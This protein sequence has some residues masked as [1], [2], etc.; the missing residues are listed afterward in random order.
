MPS[1]D[2][3]L[4]TATPLQNSLLELFG[5]VS[6]IDEH[7]FGDLKSFREQF[8]EL[9]AGAQVSSIEGA[10]GADLPSHAAPAGDGLHPLHE[11][12]ALV[13]EFTPDEAEDSLY[14]LGLGILAARQSSGASRQPALA[15]DARP[16]QAPRLLDVR[17]R[18]RAGHRWPSASKAAGRSRPD[19]RSSRS[20]TRTT[21]RW[22]KRPRNGRTTMPEPLRPRRPRALER[23]IAELRRV[24]ATSQPPSSRTPKGARF[25]KALEVGFA[26]AR[27]FGRRK[28]NHLHGV[29]A[30][31]VLLLRVLAD[32]P[33][34]NV[35]CC[36]TAPIPTNGQGDL[37]RMAGAPRGTDRVTGSKTAD[38][39]SALVDYF[40]D[41]G[42]IMIATEAGAEGHQSSVLLAGRQLRPA[43]EPAADRAAYRS[44]P[45]LRP[46]AR[47]RR[48][49]FPEPQER[50][51]PA[52]LSAS[53][54]RSSSSSKACSARATKCSAPS[55]RASISRSGSLASTSNAGKPTRSRRPSSSCSRS[56][57]SRSIEAMTQ[58]RQKLLE[59]FDDEVREKLK[60]RNEDTN[61]HLNHFE[62]QLMKLADMNWM[63]LRSSSTRRHSGLT[64]CRI[65]LMAQPV[66]TG[67]YELPRRTGE[68]H[69]FRVN[70]PLGE[71]II[72]R[73]RSRELRWQKLSST[74][75][76]HEGG[77]RRRAAGRKIGLAGGLVL[78][79]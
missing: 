32:S 47:R 35:S 31:P 54:R 41:Q 46:E 73:A 53:C 77:F 3:L 42:Q 18:R 6:F 48:R 61:L 22:T 29:P 72:Q 63:G 20:S 45:P 70:H 79:G 75:R 5:L 11:A 14:N 59:N 10:T 66:P 62:Q 39:R 15:H 17:H 27:E 33:L 9:N 4:L 68:A 21:R 26:K 37:R 2:K 71:A 64:L 60:I 52:R 1:G 65:G 57:T 24:R 69:F 58:A 36:S 8:S 38:M 50:G 12:P 25:L 16:A 76:S 13:E 44:L 74:T 49:Q 43:V 30:D 78:V 28:G 19:S 40:R 56:S 55:S 67:L 7:A 23:E 34:R 51:G